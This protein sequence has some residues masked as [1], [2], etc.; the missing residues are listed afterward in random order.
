MT[1][2]VVGVY[3]DNEARVA[4]ADLDALL[5]RRAGGALGSIGGRAVVFRRETKDASLVIFD[6]GHE[7]LAKFCFDRLKELAREK[8]G[9]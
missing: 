5:E 1:D 3:G 9:R 8:A 6:G 2:R 7:M 4:Q